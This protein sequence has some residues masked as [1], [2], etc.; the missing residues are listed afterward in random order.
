LHLKSRVFGRRTHPQLQFQEAR[1]S[2]LW[3]IL[4]LRVQELGFVGAAGV[5]VWVFFFY[6]LLCLGTA[7]RPSKKLKKEV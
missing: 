2:L 1:A 5:I 4:A 3:R 7:P 6:F